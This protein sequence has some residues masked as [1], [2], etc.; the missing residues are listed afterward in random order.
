M[1]SV[2]A[3]AALLSLGGCCNTPY[4]CF[5]NI[6]NTSAAPVPATPHPRVML[7]ALINVLN[8]SAGKTGD[9]GARYIQQVPA[10]VA[11]TH[12]RPSLLNM[13]AN[14]GDD[15]PVKSAQ[16]ANQMGALPFITL[17]CD[18]VARVAGGSDD[19]YYHRWFA[20][21]AVYAKPV[22]V[23][24]FH[25]MNLSDIHSCNTKDQSALFV[26]AFQRIAEIAH[27]T[28]PNAKM[29]WCPSARTTGADAYYPGDDAVDVIAGD[30][31]ANRGDGSYE[32]GITAG[33]FPAFF[34][35][36]APHGKPM[37]IAETAAQQ[38]NQAD[39]IASLRSLPPG[40]VGIMWWD[41]AGGLSGG[42]P[43]FT[44]NFSPDGARAWG[45]L[46]VALNGAVNSG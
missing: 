36:Y 45:A 1:R 9:S 22:Y 31:Y 13:Y 27:K 18:D 33:P 7:G 25:E 21:I 32:G 30:H 43:G 4:G 37:M 5:G 26:T 3:L 41:S 23:R 14:F 6:V 29:V 44:W 42:K 8:L 12:T 34:A 38:P 35:H 46:D 15:F 11:L 40:V 20:Q 24:T 39:Y 10:F 16:A 2:L 28:A 17:R 19:A